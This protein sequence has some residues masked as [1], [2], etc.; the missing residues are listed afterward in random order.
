MYMWR[1]RKNKILDFYS[2]NIHS[3]NY[4]CLCNHQQ[5][6]IFLDDYSHST[7]TKWMAIDLNLSFVSGWVPV[8]LDFQSLAHGLCIFT[9]SLFLIF[10]V[11]EQHGRWFLSSLIKWPFLKLLRMRNHSVEHMVMKPS[12]RVLPSILLSVVVESDTPDMLTAQ[13]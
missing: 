11:S 10:R 6:R 9:I 8:L 5:L 13:G 2:S 3:V 12:Q 7:S 1:M 4:S